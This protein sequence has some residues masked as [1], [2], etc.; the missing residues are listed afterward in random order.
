MKIY[1]LKE[2]EAVNFI[3]KNDEARK[4]YLKTYFNKDI[5]DPLLYHLIINTHLISFKR[6]VE[7]IG[8]SIMQRFP[9]EFNI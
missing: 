5:D 1:N 2:A 8:N 3:E 6:A 4:N 9:N 7:L